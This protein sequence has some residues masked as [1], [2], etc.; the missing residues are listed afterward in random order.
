MAVEAEK[1]Q[2]QLLTTEQ[3]L[4]ELCRIDDIWGNVIGRT[5]LERVPVNNEPQEL[6]NI[7]VLHVEFDSLGET[8]AR[9]RNLALFTLYGFAHWNSMLVRPDDINRC[10]TLRD[11]TVRYEPGVHEV[12]LDLTR[13]QWDFRTMEDVFSAVE[14]SENYSLAHS[15]VLSLAGLHRTA[16]LKR[17]GFAWQEL[18]YLPGYIFSDRHFGPDAKF[19]LQFGAGKC[20]GEMGIRP[21]RVPGERLWGAVP[22]VLGKSKGEA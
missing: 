16:F 6:D 14:Q 2:G 10:T 13:N 8:F 5:A 7:R 15:E 20:D 17:G 19:L 21:D 1:Y 11:Q 18:P 12:R 4:E 22:L 9:W 3:Q